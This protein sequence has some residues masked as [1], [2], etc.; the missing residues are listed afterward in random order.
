M[1]FLL[2]KL[3]VKYGQSERSE[4]MRA[5]VGGAPGSDHLSDF[6]KGFEGLQSW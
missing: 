5:I 1:I 2:I 6:E 3:A 4:S